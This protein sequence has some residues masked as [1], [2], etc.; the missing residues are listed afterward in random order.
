M[1]K[2]KANISRLSVVEVAWFL[3]FL[4]SYTLGNIIGYTHYIT[5]AMLLLAIACTNKGKLS[6]RKPFKSIIAFYVAFIV[7]MFLSKLWASEASETQK[8]II[9]AMI[10]IVI[11][12]LCLIDYISSKDRLLSLIK[13][14]ILATSVFACI[15]YL[16]SPI[17]TWGTEG[18]GGFTPIWRNAAGYYFAYASFF[19]IYLYGYLK[20]THGE[21]DKWLM[22]IGPFLAVAAVGT[23]SRKVV[24]QLGLFVILY[25]LLHRGLGKKVKLLL[26]A[27][28]AVIVV[29]AV[30]M[31]IPA[32]Q[33]I[34][35]GR[36]L[37][38]FEGAAS[39]DSSTITRAYMREYAFELFLKHPV[40][41]SGLNGYTSWLAHNTN[42][43]SRWNMTATYSHCNYT[44]LLA[45]SGI[46]GFGLYYVFMVALII[47]SL[48]KYYF[49]FARLG[50][51]TVVSFIILDYGT[52][53]YYMRFY[54]FV[55]F[56][57]FI[58]L[59]LE[60]GDYDAEE[61]TV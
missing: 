20:N 24:V 16:S 50:I 38:I 6:I 40:I 58:C 57:G 2:K 17:R 47:K 31:Q 53:S 12:L 1:I 42:F 43:L 39:T 9:I 34:Y 14:F 5:T 55:L 35:A 32:F 27:V 21:Y 49:P 25:V 56:I 7:W 52:I 45:N 60:R 54:L 15:Y 41:G 23:G 11:M 18:M 44:E 48:K 3:Y 8:T 51:I 28:I 13:I 30:G 10:E 46:I 61:Y 4:M 29:I 33:S 26:G 36:L 59:K 22:Y 19:S 37:S